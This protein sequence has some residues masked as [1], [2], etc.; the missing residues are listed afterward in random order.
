MWRIDL[1]AISMQLYN[2]AESAF[3]AA[4]AAITVDTAVPSSGTMTVQKGDATLVIMENKNYVFL[5]GAKEFC[6]SVI[7]HI[8]GTFYVSTTVLDMIR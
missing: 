1:S 6:N 8:S 7:V 3:T 5:N 4:G 2:D